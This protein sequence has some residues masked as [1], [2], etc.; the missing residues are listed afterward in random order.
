M[1]DI[2]LALGAGCR[3]SPLFLGNEVQL[4]REHRL[5]HPLLRDLLL[6]LHLAA[7]MGGS[8]SL[9]GGKAPAFAV[10]GEQSQGPPREGEGGN[11]GIFIQGQEGAGSTGLSGAGSHPSPV[12]PGSA[13]LG[14]SAAG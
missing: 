2:G 9:V 10:P 11:G 5:R 7:A 1:A 12:V 14:L 6:T 4:P 8:Q 3:K 13:P